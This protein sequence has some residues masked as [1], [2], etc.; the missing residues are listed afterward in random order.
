[1]D[2]ENGFFTEESTPKQ[3]NITHTQDFVFNSSTKCIYCESAFLDQELD[4]VF[5]LACCTQCRYTNIKFV[6][7]T[8]ATK[9]YL[10]CENDLKNLKF[11]SRPNPHKG[12]WHDMCLYL[13]DQIRTIS[14]NKYGDEEVLEEIK[15][16]RVDTIKRRKI[17][18]LKTKIRDLKRKTF[19]DKEEKK[20]HV[21]EFV[22]SSNIKKC[23][24]CGMEIEQENI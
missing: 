3:R 11:I 1:M 13:E 2:N 15:N 19:V 24:E 9:H 16:K 8:T 20:K 10:L 7:K 21:H 4:K 14:M 5:G 23:K 17:K 6:T 12:N 22:G 18:K